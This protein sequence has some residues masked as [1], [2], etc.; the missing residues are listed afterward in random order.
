[1]KTLEFRKKI[2]SWYSK[3]RR[4]LPWRDNPA[5]Y[6]VWLSEIILQ[7]TRVSQGIIYFNSFIEKFPDI[8]SLAHANEQEVL[9]LWQGLGYY[10]RARNLHAA[11]KQLSANN[12]QLP[13]SYKS[14]LKL[15]G[16]G[17][18][19]AAAIASIAFKEP[20]AA[21]DGNVMRVISRFYGINDP[22]NSTKGKKLIDMLSGELIDTENP[23][24]FNQAMM[25]LG[26]TVCTPKNY[27]CPIC[28]VNSLCIAFSANIVHELPKKIKR[29]K[30]IT[31]YFNYLVIDLGNSLIM[32]KR[33]NN[34]IWKN[35]YD[36]PLIETSAYADE[37]AIFNNPIWKSW[38]S[39]SQAT[40]LN[41]TDYK[42]HLLTHQ[43]LMVRFYHISVP[44]LKNI[45][46][47][48]H[49][50]DKIDIFD[51]PVPKIIECFLSESFSKI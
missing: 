50:T 1:M 44:Q 31:R 5:P 7:Q 13:S 42:K 35:L 14:L 25:E 2:L 10:S 49:K 43:E 19:T 20:V 45:P 32:K 4:E 36:F 3:N 51:L 30:T 38:F 34:D 27:K 24:D 6:N 9:K 18:Y 29:K 17:P 39:G 47:E 41:V 33:Y 28:P 26:A 12:Y 37:T 8:K 48:F 15:K 23:G 46:P 40:I 21:V 16:V 22:V 11:A